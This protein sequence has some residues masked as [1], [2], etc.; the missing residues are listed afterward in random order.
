M[1]CQIYLSEQP[2][3]GNEV[4]RFLQTPASGGMVVFTGTVR[5]HFE[6][7]KVIRLEFEA[8]QAMA[9][10][11]MERL[12]VICAE[13]WPCHR[14]AIHHRTGVLQVGEIPVIIGVSCTHRREAFAACQFLIDT[15]K[16]SIPI[17]KKEVFQ[18][19]SHWV[20]AHP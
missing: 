16:E 1:E 4:F 12:A 3:D 8:Y 5:D 6:D 18:D 14:I 7:K 10:K 20:S 13:K 15:L 17:W 2:L 9:V 11:E 19:G